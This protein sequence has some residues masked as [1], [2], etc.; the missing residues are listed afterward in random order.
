MNN[1]DDRAKN[2]Y[3]ADG[4]AGTSRSVLPNLLEHGMAEELLELLDDGIIV[5]DEQRRLVLVNRSAEKLTGHPREALLGRDCHKTFN[6]V[7]RYTTYRGTRRW[8]SP[9]R[10]AR[11]ATRGSS[12]R[13]W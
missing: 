6:E 8:C 13:R 1:E 11:C 9:V 3:S 5:H 7:G 2:H 4:W 10:T 12:P